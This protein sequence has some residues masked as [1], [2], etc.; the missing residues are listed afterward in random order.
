MISFTQLCFLLLILFLIFGDTK[1][2]YKKLK[3]LFLKKK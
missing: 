3:Q 1:T 2:F